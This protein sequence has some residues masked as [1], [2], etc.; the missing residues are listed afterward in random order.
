L[1][2]PRKF[3]GWW[4]SFEIG[5][6]VEIDYDDVEHAEQRR[7]ARLLVLLVNNAPAILDALRSAQEVVRVATNQDYDPPVIGE[8]E[9]DLA[10]LTGE[11]LE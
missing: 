4:K 7:I 11:K 3:E 2:L 6:G 1:V 5:M 9:H 8:L 10:K